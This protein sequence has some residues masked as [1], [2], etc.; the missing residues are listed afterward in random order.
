MKFKM[1]RLIE[2]IVE[3]LKPPI[4]TEHVQETQARSLPSEE[5]VIGQTSLS[6]NRHG[7]RCLTYKDEPDTP[8]AFKKF[9]CL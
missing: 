2:T 6:T 8:P 4:S 3:A 1:K 7:A 9:D 5:L